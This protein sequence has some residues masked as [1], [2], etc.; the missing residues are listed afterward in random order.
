MKRLGLC[1]LLLGLATV[2]YAGEGNEPD[3]GTPGPQGP[4]GTQG[5]QGP[6][7]PTGATGPQG[8]TGAQGQAGTNGKD[9]KDANSRVNYW[10]GTD[11][12]GDFAIRLY[13]GKRVQLQAFTA[14]AFGS[15]PGQDVIGAGRNLQ[16]GVRFVF[17]LGKSYEE[18]MLEKQAA[19]IRALTAALERLSR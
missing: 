9:G 18:R 3:G 4:Q 16:T 13:D 10:R 19:D 12:V 5:P 1:L 15:E 8:S 6:Q 14:Y 2:G 7:G 17:K 11:L